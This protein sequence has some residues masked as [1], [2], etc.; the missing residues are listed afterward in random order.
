MLATASE[1]RREK[2]VSAYQIASVYAALGER[3]KAFAWLETAV[4]ER[5]SWMNLLKVDPRLDPLRTDARFPQ[6]LQR[7]GL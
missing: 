2:Y 4:R 7:A 1:M 3:E 6:F 5:D